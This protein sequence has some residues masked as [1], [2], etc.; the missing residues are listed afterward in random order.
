M[1]RKRFTWSKITYGEKINSLVNYYAYYGDEELGY[2][3]YYKPWKNCLGI[4][5]ALIRNISTG[6]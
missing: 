2:L 4:I 3:E 5:S 6:I 1:G